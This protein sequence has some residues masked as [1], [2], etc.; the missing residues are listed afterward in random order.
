MPRNTGFPRIALVDERRPLS[1]GAVLLRARRG[2][3]DGILDCIRRLAAYEKEPDV[4]QTT[5]DDQNQALFGLSP[6]VFAVSLP[7]KLFTW[8]RL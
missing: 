8:Q 1:A 7:R 6:S 3:E 4:V 2:D 5:P